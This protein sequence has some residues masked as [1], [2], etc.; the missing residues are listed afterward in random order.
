MPPE[1][2]AKAWTRRRWNGP[3]GA[4][5]G[6]METTFAREADLCSTFLALVPDS[7]LV[8][9]ETGGF[10]ILLVRKEDGFQIG[11]QAKLRLNAKV[12]CQAL[13]TGRASAITNP[14]PDCRAVLV[15]KGAWAETWPGSAPIWA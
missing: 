12:V 15:P 14:N 10:D 2:C 8:Y 6:N 4:G 5:R 3:D 7:W 13:E 1:L 11:V 9:A